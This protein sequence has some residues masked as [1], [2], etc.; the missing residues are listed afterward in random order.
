MSCLNTTGAALCQ[1][2]L[3]GFPGRYLHIWKTEI[4]AFKWE[5]E[6]KK[7]PDAKGPILSPSAPP[8]TPPGFGLGIFSP[9]N[10]ATLHH[11]Q[12]K[13]LSPAP[14]CHGD[15]D[16]PRASREDEGWGYRLDRWDEGALKPPARLRLGSAGRRSDQYVITR[17]SPA[18][19]G[20]VV[21][22]FVRPALTGVLG[23]CGSFIPAMC[24][25]RFSPLSIRPWEPA[26][27]AA[28]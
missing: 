5:G 25:W 12:P 8:S 13:K 11:F 16:I 17:I 24:S 27:A 4:I 6:K 15:E 20:G 28:P 7:N 9:L 14:R 21:K 23:F 10:P 18:G 1:L 22:M 2:C 26:T 3:P 19:A